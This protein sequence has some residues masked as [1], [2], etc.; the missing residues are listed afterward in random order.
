MMK[1]PTV[2]HYAMHSK[3][4][5]SAPVYTWPDEWMS[6]KKARTLPYCVDCI[7]ILSEAHSETILKKPS[8]IVEEKV[9]EEPEQNTFITLSMYLNRE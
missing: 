8:V 2:M 4:V 7:K 5:C 6:D 9:I 1:I 3:T